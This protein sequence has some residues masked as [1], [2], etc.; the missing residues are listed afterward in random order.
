L[1]QFLS[2]DPI[3]GDKAHPQSRDPYAYGAGDPIDSVDP[4]GLCRSIDGNYGCRGAAADSKATYVSTR[5]TL[6][7]QA[8]AKVDT[9]APSKAL[10][11]AVGNSSAQTAA[12]HDYQTT[13]TSSA[14]TAGG[15]GYQ[16][17]FTSTAQSLAQAFGGAGYDASFKL[18]GATSAG[19]PRPSDTLPNGALWITEHRGYKEGLDAAAPAA[20][21]GMA[22]TI[23]SARFV[24]FWGVVACANM[25]ADA[26][27]LQTKYYTTWDVGMEI[28][29]AGYLR[30]AYRCEVGGGAC[31]DTP[32]LFGRVLWREYSDNTETEHEIAWLEFTTSSFQSQW[33]KF[34]KDPVGFNDVAID[35]TRTE[36][37]EEN[38]ADNDFR[39]LGVKLRTGSWPLGDDWVQ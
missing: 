15:G 34:F 1:G 5:N 12:G 9:Q 2:T 8:V 39:D 7:A 29:G 3:A 32:S 35:Y 37:I 13:F 18:W 22:C 11:Q 20:I 27:G 21:F 10:A 23:V 31:T 19:G 14:Q 30:L 25:A 38:D 24:F 26:V 16:T 36:H 4:Y 28:K 33:R 6:G 17:T